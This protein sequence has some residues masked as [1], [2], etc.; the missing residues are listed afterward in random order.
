[1]AIHIANSVLFECVC[2]FYD[3]CFGYDECFYPAL[4]KFYTYE[5]DIKHSNA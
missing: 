3:R 1:M 4:P 5:L 2:P